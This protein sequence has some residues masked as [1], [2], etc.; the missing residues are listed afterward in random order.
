MGLALGGPLHLV[1]DGFGMASQTGDGDSVQGP[2]QGA[3]ATAVETVAG[4]LA[5]ARF[6]GRDASQRG[7]RCLAADPPVM[8][9]RDQQLRGNDWADSGLGEQGWS[10]RVLLDQVM[11]W[12]SSSASWADAI[13][14]TTASRPETQARLVRCRQMYDETDERG[15]DRYAVAPSPR[16]SASRAKSTPRSAPHRRSWPPAEPGHDLHHFTD[17]S[18]I[19]NALGPQAR[20]PSRPIKRLLAS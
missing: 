6:D 2:V 3:V 18:S 5:A 13:L 10:C 8:R 16:N 19:A 9:P 7:E 20:Q 4:T 1:G 12:G 15:R 11:S 14:T 17:T